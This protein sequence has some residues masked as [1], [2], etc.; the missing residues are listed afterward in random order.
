MNW[1]IGK[2]TS[3][4]REKERERNRTQI[5]KLHARTKVRTPTKNQDIKSRKRN[6]S[7]MWNLFLNG[8][9]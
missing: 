1:T 9:I 2:E 8:A 3:R 6:I 7:L 4:Q 5:Y